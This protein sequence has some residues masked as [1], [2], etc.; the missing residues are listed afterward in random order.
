MSE[1]TPQQSYLIIDTNIIQFA[2]TSPQN[3]SSQIVKY[4]L[5]LTSNQN[6]IGAISQVTIYEAIQRCNE[7]KEDE[8]FKTLNLFTQLD[9]GKQ[10]LIMAAWLADLYRAERISDTQISDCDKI[11]AATAFISKSV[12]LTA[13]PNDFPRPFFNE[14]DKRIITYKNIKNRDAMIVI[15]LLEPDYEV[16]NIK[17][18]ERQKNP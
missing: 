5:E 3:R 1:T 15:Y 11:I 18:I 9:A 2:G 4:I 12:I 8:A 16:T 14:K 17:F 7:A 6:F 10:V 13:N